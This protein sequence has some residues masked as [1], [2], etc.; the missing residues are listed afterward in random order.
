VLAVSFVDFSGEC[1]DY[2]GTLDPFDAKVMGAHL[3]SLM[4]ETQDPRFEPRLG[5]PN[6][7]YIGAENREFF[8]QRVAEEYFLGTALRAGAISFPV[9]RAMQQAESYIRAEIGDSSR[10]YPSMSVSVDVELGHDVKGRYGPVLFVARGARY[11]VINILGHW[12]EG[13]K[14]REF[15]KGYRVQVEGGK[16]LSLIQDVEGNIWTCE[17]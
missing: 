6:L 9:L 1:I 4:T 13:D 14:N 17:E 8:A 2:C 10:R 12:E 5:R 7:I 16:E 3:V 11:V 15:R